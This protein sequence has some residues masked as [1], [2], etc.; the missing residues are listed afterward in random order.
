MEVKH[1]SNDI[2]EENFSKLLI[3][4]SYFRCQTATCDGGHWNKMFLIDKQ[5][6]SIQ[7]TQI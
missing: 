4:L 6:L 7:E 1:F 5:E 3:E 2:Y